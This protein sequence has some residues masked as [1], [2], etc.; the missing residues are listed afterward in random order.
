MTTN[1]HGILVGVEGDIFLIEDLGN[2]EVRLATMPKTA[3]RTDRLKE[4]GVRV[5]HC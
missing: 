1:L 4:R 3:V 5:H 2:V